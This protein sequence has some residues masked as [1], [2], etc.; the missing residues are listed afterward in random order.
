MTAVLDKK[1]YGKLLTKTLPHV[2]TSAK[3]HKEML[4]RAEELMLNTKRSA[5]ETELL[6]LVVA[7]IEDWER[8]IKLP[9]DV[10][11][12]DV[13]KFL[14]EA[15]KHQPSDLWGIIDKSTLSNILSEARPSISKAVAKTLGDFYHVSP[16]V[17]I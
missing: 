11:P 6:K 13:L 16:G 12:V 17:F 7:L 4:S 15:H 14:M 9:E 10:S 5:S 1:A 2:I 8:N 3:E